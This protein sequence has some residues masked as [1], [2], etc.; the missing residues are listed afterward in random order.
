[1][2]KILVAVDGSDASA[3]AATFAAELAAP[4]L[5]EL[6]LVHAVEP[7]PFLAGDIPVSYQDM[8]SLRE[9]QGK[10]LLTELEARL[11]P[12]DVPLRTQLVHG[13]PAEVLTRLAKDGRYDLV[14]VAS[15]GRNAVSRVLVGS[16]TD[17]LVHLCEQPV[18]VV[19]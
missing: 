19:R 18:L 4:H 13:A 17:R 3:R 1:M 16:V 5:A 7:Y 2:K 10:A 8:A 12:T 11:R 6:T 15:K 14:V 9:R